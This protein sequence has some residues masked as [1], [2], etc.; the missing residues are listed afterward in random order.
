MSSPLSGKVA[1][2]TGGS[3]G[4]GAAITRRLARD[5]ADVAFSY[6]SNTAR[7]EEIAAAIS[8]NGVRAL[9]IQA[10]QADPVA[11]AKF[12]RTVHA[13]FG[14]LNIL[15]NSA[16]ITVGGRIDDL[17]ADV[18]AIQHM[19]SV[20]LHGVVATVR[21]A[22]PIMENGGRIVSIGS[23]VA[24]H[25]AFS[26]FADYTAAK[27]AIAA[28]TRG[29]ARDLGPRGITVNV[30]QPGA[31]ETESNPNSGDF[32]KILARMAALGRYGQA[33]EV[34]G[35]VAFLVGPDAAF[36]TGAT[37]NVDGGQAT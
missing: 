6:A 5:G 8:A 30:I 28:Y 3:R 11:V 31:I 14:R 37:L 29:W 19:L 2:V 17:S 27:A 24:S 26:G 12:V 4:I 7:A 36:V 10:D 15:V 21:A 33:E 13:H 23:V 25:I 22:A 16:G 32:A 1:I 34:A 35:A 18:A 20:N 9:P